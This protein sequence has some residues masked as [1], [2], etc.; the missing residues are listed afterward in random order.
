[1]S[2]DKLEPP[3]FFNSE[4]GP[5]LTFFPSTEDGRP[6]MNA[7]I[8]LSQGGI[9]DRVIVL[10]VGDVRQLHDYLRAWLTLHMTPGEA[11]RALGEALERLAAFQASRLKP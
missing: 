6:I 8:R 5:A 9:I 10:E 11:S 4:T 1:M 7:H 2:E 3:V